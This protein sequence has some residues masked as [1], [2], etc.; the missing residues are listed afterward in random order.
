MY[1]TGKSSLP[2]RLCN[3]PLPLQK[4]GQEGRSTARQFSP[5]N[6]SFILER[7]LRAIKEHAAKEKFPDKAVLYR[8][9]LCFNLL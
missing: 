9:I 1:P 5:G 6:S 7:G 3:A 8:G 4:T 2:I